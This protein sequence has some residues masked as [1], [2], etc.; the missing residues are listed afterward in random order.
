MPAPAT[1]RRLATTLGGALVLALLPMG[2]L[3]AVLTARSYSAWGATHTELSA[4]Q[5]IG[6]GLPILIWLAALLAGW[7][8]ID[9]LVVKPLRAIERG[10]AIYGASTNPGRTQLRFGARDFGSAEL[11]S[12]AA[13]FDAMANEIDE[14]SRNLHSALVEQKRLTREVHHR[15]KNNLQIVSSL[16]SLQARGADTP[17]TAQ[18]YGAIQTR[19]AAL[20]QVHRW[21]YDEPNCNGVDL[22]SLARDLC[23]GLQASLLSPCHPEVLVMCEAAPNMIHPD[24]A[25]PVAFLV[26]ELTNLAA[27]HAPE[28]PLTVRVTSTVANSETCLAIEAP[29]FIGVDS[30]SPN[31]PTPTARI[32]HGMARQLRS[33]LVHDPEAGRY[34][35]TFASAAG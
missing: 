28:G 16:L 30:I 29:A 10:M 35:V 34:S 14:N 32:I 9:R 1:N 15:V 3:A 20:M 27:L 8:A 26:T 31:S 17:E 4:G 5:A 6:I 19:L 7:F 22:K 11:A 12:L 2:L 24:A 21:M 13:S 25:V 18:T 33:A 23:A